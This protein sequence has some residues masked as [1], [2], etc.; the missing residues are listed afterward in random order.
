[1]G[2]PKPKDGVSQDMEQTNSNTGEAGVYRHPESGAESIATSDPLFGN[3]MA[4]GLIR[5][6]YVRVGDVPEDV[7]RPKPREVFDN[8]TENSALKGVNARLDKLDTELEASKTRTEELEAENAKLREQLAAGNSEGDSTEGEEEET[9]EAKPL[10]KDNYNEAELRAI[11]EAEGVE[12]T[13]EH[14]TKQKIVDAVLAA[15]EEKENK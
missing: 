11:A 8:S 2:L 6:G 13:D 15:R 1:M 10:T 7:L 14:S 3:A 4:E 9:P 5:V 12:L